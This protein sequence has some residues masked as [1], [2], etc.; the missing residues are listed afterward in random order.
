ML[1][2]PNQSQPIEPTMPFVQINGLRLFF[3]EQGPTR[4]PADGEAPTVVFVH[5]TQG[6]ASLWADL[7]EALSDR[8]R[9]A[10]LNHRG[11]S[12]SESPDDP[13]AYSIEQFADDQAAFIERRGYAEVTMIGWSLGVRTVLA[14]LDRHGA[15]R[16]SR[17]ILVSGPPSP[18]FGGQPL[19]APDQAA[20]LRE[21]WGE[22]FGPAT[23]AC[24][25]GSNASRATCDLESTLPQIDIPIAIFHGRHD[26]IAPYAAAEFMAR[27]I[28]NSTL[29][30]F[31]ASGHA[32]L[33]SE[34]E[35]FAAE[36]IGFI[37]RCQREA[38]GQMGR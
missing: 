13:S 1:P 18:N 38:S 28:P 24:W 25:A 34:P 8:F 15:S 23:P 33:R 30:T 26:P 3:H 6:N 29:R 21:V 22:R 32:P 36:T 31:E 12:P 9:C 20:P 5:G 11:R 27:S 10:A 17:A 14:Y 16:V 35:R 19:T 4:G 37:E 2:I 7:I